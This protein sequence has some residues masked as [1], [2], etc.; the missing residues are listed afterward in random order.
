MEEAGLCSISKGHVVTVRD[1]LHAELQGPRMVGHWL[2]TYLKGYA[3]AVARLS[4]FAGAI[5]ADG[6]AAV[7]AAENFAAAL[8]LLESLCTLAVLQDVPGVS[9]ASPARLQLMRYSTGP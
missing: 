4:V 2:R 9:H 7:G 6:A 5:T 8:Q 3:P 1:D